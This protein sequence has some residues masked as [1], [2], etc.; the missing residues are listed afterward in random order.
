MV[1]AMPSRRVIGHRLGVIARRH[2]DHALPRLIGTQRKHGIQRPALLEGSGELHVFEF[3]PDLGA[4]Q[5]RQGSRQRQRRPRHV[6]AN[7]V[8][9]G[10]YPGE[11]DRQTGS[12]SIFSQVAATE[13]SLLL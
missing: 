9:G 2:R 3:E 1:A 7:G 10:P 12:S 13:R 6:A 11:R 5:L 4:G 8:R